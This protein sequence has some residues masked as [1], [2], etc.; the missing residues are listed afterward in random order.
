MPPITHAISL[1]SAA[2][3]LANAPLEVNTNIKDFRTN[4]LP[5]YHL[6]FLDHYAHRAK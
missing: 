6:P 3:H 2:N 4:P 5:G 1:V